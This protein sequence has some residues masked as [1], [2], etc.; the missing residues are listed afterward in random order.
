MFFHLSRGVFSSLLS[1]LLVS[2]SSLIIDTVAGGFNDRCVTT[3]NKV[4][5]IHNEH[6]KYIS[7]LRLAP[8]VFTKKPAVTGP[9]IDAAD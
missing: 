9:R 3:N 2:F 4:F 7:G 6:N 1:S 8:S 5:A